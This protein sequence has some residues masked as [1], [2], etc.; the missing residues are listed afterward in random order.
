M[1]EHRYD[2]AYEENNKFPQKIRKLFARCQGWKVPN[3]KQV[4]ALNILC[5]PALLQ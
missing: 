5:G 1:H 4:T 3:I 2:K